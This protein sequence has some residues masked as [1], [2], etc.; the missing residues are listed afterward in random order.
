MAKMLHTVRLV[1]E[2]GLV[3]LSFSNYTRKHACRFAS[4]QCICGDSQEVIR[5]IVEIR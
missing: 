3:R 1:L 2:V 5:E 4:L